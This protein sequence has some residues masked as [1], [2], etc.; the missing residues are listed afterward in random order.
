MMIK[1]IAQ[2]IEANV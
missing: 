1:R 2:Y